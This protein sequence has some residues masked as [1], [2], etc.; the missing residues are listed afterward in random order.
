L[1]R[2]HILELPYD[3]ARQHSV[4]GVATN[5]DAAIVI[6][7][8]NLRSNDLALER[9]ELP[10]RHTNATGRVGDVEAE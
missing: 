6:A 5:G 4:H 9:S 3:F 1:C 10:Q 2:Q 7:P 8:T